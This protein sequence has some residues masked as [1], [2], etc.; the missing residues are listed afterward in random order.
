M[1]AA[2]AVVMCARCGQ[3]TKRGRR[4]QP[5]GV[6][7]S[8]CF[9]RQRRGDEHAANITEIAAAVAAVE[10]GLSARTRADAIRTAA[11]GLR[12][13]GRLVRAL[14]AEPD[15]LTSGGSTAPVVI[16][17]LVET[18]Q[19]VG[20][21]RV[22][23]PACVDCGRSTWLTQRHTGHRLCRSCGMAR[24]LEECVVCGRD[25]PIG[26]RHADGTATCNTCRVHDPRRQSLCDGCGK[27]S[28]TARRM[29]DG[30]GLCRRCWG[31]P[32]IVC[33]DCGREARCYGGARR[34]HPRC[35]A[36]AKPRE[37]CTL[38]DRTATVAARLPG[39]PVCYTCWERALLAK[40]ICGACGRLRRPDPRYAGHEPRCS[41]CAALP[42]LQVCDDCGEESRIYEADR[43]RRCVLR[44]RV[45]GLLAGPD[46]AIADELQPLAAA[47][48][49][50]EPARAGLRWIA[51][52]ETADLL[53]SL[54]A[55]QVALT[56]AALD[57]LAATK[58]VR[59]LRAVLVAV[60]VLDA[61]D[62]NLARLEAWTAEQIA[63]IEPADDRHIIDTYATW[64]VLRRHRQRGRRRPTGDTTTGRRNIT[65]ATALLA[66]LRAH[67]RTLDTATQADI[68]L[69][70]ATTSDSRRRAGHDFLRWATKHRLVHDIAITRRPEPLPAPHP[71]PAITERTDQARRL[72]HD[73]D[74]TVTDR[75]AGLLVI[76]YA[77]S[78]STIV[79]LT[80]DD[81]TIVGDV[82]SITLGRDPIE[83]PEPLG[84][85]VARLASDRTGHAT[86][87]ADPGR[88]LFPGGH[89]GRHLHPNTLSR[90]LHAQGIW[91]RAWR[92]NALFDLASDTP[93]VVL[94]HLLG[95]HTRT[96]YR[97][98]QAAGGEWTNYAA[99]RMRSG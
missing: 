33:V 44:R 4:R 60:G 27:L 34:G 64:W 62:E 79:G 80:I 72:L 90:R 63:G 52:P 68:D 49:V 11:P 1:P 84:A 83:L 22:R 2:G 36:C 5:D 57:E 46:G 86:V 35:D 54:A 48:A 38:C 18:L 92:T 66:W 75:V 61:R 17:R 98:L 10:P 24:R 76:L 6:V 58:I 73:E 82:T 53:R 78:L 85:L 94:A 21:T 13:S 37:D 15:A 16:T 43:C 89:P 97:W 50:T 30:T 91:A 81:V 45:E 23:L 74:V 87:A 40:A 65:V 95:L 39:G 70:A 29:P 55:G 7:C 28:V 99:D 25:R 59:H 20:A 8:A 41:D 26:L 88:W 3:R 77:Q 51:T 47:L 12:E 32:F 56:H 31:R 71:D 9:S 19:G 96:A 93:L 14:Q 69:W 42:P 67:D